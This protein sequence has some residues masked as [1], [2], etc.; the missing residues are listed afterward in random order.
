MAAQAIVHKVLL[1]VLPR[2]RKD[3]RKTGAV[4]PCVPC[5]IF[6]LVAFLTVGHHLED[7]GVTEPDGLGPIADQMDADM[8]QFGGKGGF[9]A[10]DAGHAT[11]H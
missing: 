11:V 1:R 4:R 6:V 8:P 3:L 9:M 2:I 10:I 7:I 5:C